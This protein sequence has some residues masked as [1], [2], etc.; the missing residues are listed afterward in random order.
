MN[1]DKK[2]YHK[3]PIYIRLL[4]I[5][6]PIVSVLVCICIGR[7][8]IDISDVLGS[9]TDIGT[10]SISS[11]IIWN[12]RL[13]RLV[14]A[15]LV[16]SGLS[17]A[18]VA[19]QSMFDNPLATPDT[20][21]VASGA[22][23][24]AVIAL[25]IG[26]NSMAVQV[27]A[28]LS[29]IIAI[30]I[31][32]TIG[33]RKNNI[34]STTDMI[35]A[36]IIISS[37]YTALISLAKYVADTESQLPSITYWLMGSL[38]S[39]T[40]SKLYIAAPMIVLGMIILS[41][42]RWRLNILTLSDDEIR[43]MGDNIKALRLVTAISATM[44]IASSVAMCGQVSWIGLLIPHLCRMIFGRDAKILVPTS[45]SLGATFMVIVDTLAR[46][47]S[48]SEIPISILTAIIG[49]PIFIYLL[50]KTRGWRA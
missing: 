12:M 46:S 23:F 13:P 15:L 7:Y 8:D 49:A 44:I 10:S 20:L 40:W 21:G 14:A 6:V 1:I 34:T 29:G 25:L 2:K 28:M 42:I 3:I 30:I 4:L 38:A 47:M 16:G 50:R 17:V 45:I 22:S 39:V 48:A 5:L 37:L 36:G 26:F 24:G 18:G 11:K 35:L 27:I 9:V 33:T 31:T 41:I 43:S 32:T 19:L